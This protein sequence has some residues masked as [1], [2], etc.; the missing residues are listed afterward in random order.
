[1]FKLKT[2]NIIYTVINAACKEDEEGPQTC[3][4]HFSREGKLELMEI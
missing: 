2:L 1:M 4:H 3:V